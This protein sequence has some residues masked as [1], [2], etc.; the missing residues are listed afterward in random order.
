[1]QLS[2]VFLI[3]EDISVQTLSMHALKNSARCNLHL[4]S[5]ASTFQKQHRLKTNHAKKFTKET[6]E[7]KKAICESK[8]F[9]RAAD[10]KMFR[11]GPPTSS[12]VFR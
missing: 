10:K 5:N 4:D 3:R 9:A 8:R 6:E 1:M 12:V 11:S 7:H 2:G